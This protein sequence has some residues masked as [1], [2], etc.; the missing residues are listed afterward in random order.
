MHPV[1]RTAATRALPTRVI[2]L[3]AYTTRNRDGNGYS[4]R[5]LRLCLVLTLLADDD[6]DKRLAGGEVLVS[7][8]AVAGSEVPKLRLKAVIDAPP[9]KVWAIVD[10]CGNYEKTMPHIAASKELAR[11]RDAGTVTCRVTAA[12]PFPLSNLTSETMGIITVEPGVRWSRTWKFLRGDYNTNTGGWVL[13]PYKGD[14][15][16]TYVEYQIHTDPKMHVP[17]VFITSAQKSSFP[18]LIKRLRE[19]TVGK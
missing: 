2:Q 13:T 18:D 6:V 15:K 5:M 1:A 19:E 4:V 12:L 14:P 17:Q 9:E 11:D 10:D 8:E 3:N 7:T 16:R